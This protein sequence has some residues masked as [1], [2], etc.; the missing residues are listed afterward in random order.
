MSPLIKIP[1]RKEQRRGPKQLHNLRQGQ[2]VRFNNIRG[3]GK[4]RFLKDGKRGQI[5]VVAK[6]SHSRANAAEKIA[7]DLIANIQR[8]KAIFD[9]LTSINKRLRGQVYTGNIT[10]R[11]Q[12][13]LG[14]LDHV[15]AMIGSGKFRVQAPV[16]LTRMKS[17]PLKSVVKESDGAKTKWQSVSQIQRKNSRRVQLIRNTA[18]IK[19]PKRRM[20]V[21]RR[22]GIKVKRLKRGG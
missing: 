21:L 13:L 18:S 14:E 11:E 8:R 19:N 17:V 5:V 2:T 15:N 3:L 4:A 1:A 9:E 12:F 20:K 7:P 6:E 10:F 22:L 16:V